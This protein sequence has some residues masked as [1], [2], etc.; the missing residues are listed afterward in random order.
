MKA[1]TALNFYYKFSS[2]ITKGD[3]TRLDG[4]VLRDTGRGC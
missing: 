3:T 1:G 2:K 4:C